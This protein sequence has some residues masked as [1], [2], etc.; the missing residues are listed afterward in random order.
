MNASAPLARA[1][2]DALRSD[3]DAIDE[4]RLVLAVDGAQAARSVPDRWLTTREAAAHLGLSVNALHKL[5]A[6][7]AVP[8]EQ[9]RRGCRCWFRR[10]ELD[11]WRAKASGNE[12][13]RFH[14]ASAHSKNYRCA[15]D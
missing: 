13:E 7:R 8:F 12:M 10:S 2:I 14:V 4:L 5:T 15:A 9:E 11:R 3:P 6:A 1:L